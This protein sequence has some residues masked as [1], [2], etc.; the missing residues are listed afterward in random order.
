MQITDLVVF[1][2]VPFVIGCRY[3][4][5]TFIDIKLTKYIECCEDAYEIAEEIKAKDAYEIAKIYKEDYDK[6]EE[7]MITILKI[8][9]IVGIIGYFIF[10]YYLVFVNTYKILIICYMII[11]LV[12]KGMFKLF[13]SDFS[14][15]NFYYDNKLKI[16]R[17][18]R[19]KSFLYMCLATLTIICYFVPDGLIPFWITESITFKSGLTSGTVLTSGLTLTITILEAEFGFASYI[20]DKEFDDDRVF[21]R[22]LKEDNM[23]AS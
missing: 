2:I 23:K 8:L 9:K 22:K 5:R 20:Q 11:I 1:V 15:E 12:A 16:S 3:I 6:C 19:L 17:L 21:F 10:I 14:H 7:K 4:V 13:D 18:I